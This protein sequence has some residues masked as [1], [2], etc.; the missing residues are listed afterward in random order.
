MFKINNSKIYIVM[1]HYIRNLKNSD[2]PNLKA[3]EL[4]KFIDQTNF[5]K[6][7]LTF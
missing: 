7:T 1:Y 6:K 2:Y 3:L 4:K 5:F